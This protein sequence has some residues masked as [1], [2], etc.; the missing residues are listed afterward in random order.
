MIG[1]SSGETTVAMVDPLQKKQ[2]FCMEQRPKCVSPD[3]HPL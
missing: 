1:G 3:L 2:T